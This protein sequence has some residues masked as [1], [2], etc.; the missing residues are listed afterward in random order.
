MKKG[1]FLALAALMAAGATAALVFLRG[2]DEPKE[3]QSAPGSDAT[4]ADPDKT[5]AFPL[6]D[7][8]ADYSRSHDDPIYRF[9]LETPSGAKEVTVDKAQYETYYIGDEVVCEETPGGLRV[10]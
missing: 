2:T 1:T 9:S 4:S 10:V 6:K 5:V 7:K 3:E 8:Y